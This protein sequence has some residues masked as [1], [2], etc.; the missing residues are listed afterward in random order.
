MEH[1]RGTFSNRLINRR[2]FL[3][4]GG[5]GAAGAFLL[6]STGCGIL[7]G[8]Q[9][10]QQR[11]LV[12]STSGGAGTEATREG[13]L[14][15]FTKQTGIEAVTQ[16]PTDYAQLRSMVEAGQVTWNVL[17]ITQILVGDEEQAR[18]YF[19]PVDYSIVKAEGI[20]E[21]L[22]RRFGVGALQYSLVLGYNN[23][24]L[25]EEPQSWADFFDVERFPGKRAFPG[26]YVEY[27]FPLE[28][29]LMGDGVAPDELY[30]LDI[31]R[32]LA[33]LD[34]I[35]DDLVFF[36]GASEGEQ[37]LRDGE[38]VMADIYH[39]RTG[40]LEQEGL[41]IR[42]QWNQ[43]VAV[44]DYLGVAKGASRPDDSFRLI[45]F[46]VSAENN[47]RYTEY[48]PDAPVNKDSADRI[49]ED[50]AKYLPVYGDR[51]EQA[52]NPDLN[53]WATNLEE[54]SKRYEQWLLG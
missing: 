45:D 52:V 28:I 33:K 13:W 27:Y 4:L 23:E 36:E 26:S 11:P 30:P 48:N 37:L 5:A 42:T 1:S 7:G 38:V 17:F 39:S 51:L 35:R 31:D 24:Q 10:G 40:L 49:P 53:W 15:P 12:F 9:Q 6:G 18:S 46:A 47:Y 3:R 25:Q 8:Q 43:N 34:T 22:R 19:E 21:N 54:A 14:K 32:A 2:D 29:A 20:P 44:V 41:P 50:L 16:A